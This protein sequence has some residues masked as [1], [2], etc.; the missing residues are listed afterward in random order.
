[1]NATAQGADGAHGPSEVTWPAAISVHP[2]AELFPLLAV[3]E[4]AA[5]AEDI[6]AHGLMH[7][8]VRDADG[9]ILDGRNR[10][11]A[12]QLVGVSPD[13]QRHEG[14]P[15]SYVIST[16]L[17]RRHLTDGQRAMIGARIA[18]RR[19]GRPKTASPDAVSDLPPSAEQAAE[20]LHTSRTHIQRAQTVLKHGTSELRTATETGAVPVATAARV[21]TILPPD[22]QNEFVAKVDGGAN[23]RLIAPP[24][25]APVP[26]PVSRIRTRSSYR[27]TGT[28]D[29]DAINRFV[30]AINGFRAGLDGVTAIDQSIMDSEVAQWVSDLTNGIAALTRFRKL[31]RE[32]TA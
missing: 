28:L 31:L 18:T 5:L 20:L 15:W 4:L 2:A 11:L 25:H 14:E 7:P 29:R 24:E 3:S 27:N 19:E 30:F 32:R 12:C 10:Y 9:R 13:Y 6:T 22:E 17:H 16:N 26:V 23:P 8:I 21:A 1:M